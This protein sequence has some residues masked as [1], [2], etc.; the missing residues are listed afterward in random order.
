MK[1]PTFYEILQ[2][3]SDASFEVISSAYRTIM[4]KLRKHPDLG[5]DADEAAR[6][7]EAYETLSDPSRRARYDTELAKR[8]GAEDENSPAS[9]ERRRVPRHAVDT[10][11]S[12]CISHDQNWYSARVK[13]VSILGIRIQSHQ[14]FREGQQLVIAPTNLASPAIHGTVRWRRMFHPSWF[15]RIYEAG[16][17]FSDQITDIDERIS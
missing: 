7:N 10:T 6:I 13:D 3:A 5:G 15:E 2:V 12:Y 11:V 4:S 9:V 14:P 8:G 1:R 17:E 16:I